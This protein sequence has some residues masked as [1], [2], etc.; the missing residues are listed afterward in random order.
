MDGIRE[1]LALYRGSFLSSVHSHMSVNDVW[2]GFVG[3]SLGY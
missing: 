3:G 1:H 2:V